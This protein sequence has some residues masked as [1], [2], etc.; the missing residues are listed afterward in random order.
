MAIQGLNIY[1]LNI[2]HGCS[3]SIQPITKPVE[4]FNICQCEVRKTGLKQQKLMEE[5]YHL[6]C[7]SFTFSGVKN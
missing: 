5:L 6:G 4:I 2:Q 7:F 3:F 1:Q